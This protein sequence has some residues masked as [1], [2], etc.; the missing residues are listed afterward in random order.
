MEEIYMWIEQYSGVSYNI[1]DNE[2]LNDKYLPYVDPYEWKT[3]ILMI[4]DN[5]PDAIEVINTYANLIPDALPGKKEM[6][7]LV[8]EDTTGRILRNIQRVLKDLDL[9]TPTIQSIDDLANVVNALGGL[10]DLLSNT[11]TED[12]LKNKVFEEYEE[13]N[14]DIL[15]EMFELVKS[16]LSNMKFT[17]TAK[18]DEYF[19]LMEDEE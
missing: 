8:V 1:A 11:S 5:L 6:K 14:D 12:L 10:I 18:H 16:D 19:T 13:E 4:L 15:E 2:D 17:V 7:T 9:E 3:N